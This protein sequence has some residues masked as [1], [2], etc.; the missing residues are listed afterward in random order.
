[1]SGPD[2][3][4]SPGPDSNS[5]GNFVIGVST[6]GDI[7]PFNYLRTIISQ[8]AN[9]EI[10]T[11]LIANMD[12]Y[13]DQTAN[14]QSLFDMIWNVDTAQGY[15]LDVWGRIVG[16]SRTLNVVSPGDYFGF[17]EALPGSQ[18]F[19]QSPFYI[20]TPLTTNYEL[21]DSAFRV[22][23]FAKALSN[24]CDGSIPAIN[25]I[26]MKLFPNRGNA[27]V[28]DGLDMTMIYKF[29]FV[30]TP[31]ELAIVL[32]SGVLPKPTGVSATVQQVG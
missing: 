9:S 1:M 17:Q 16:V 3:P 8:Y 10:L 22:L 12:A 5:I 6:I 13:I 29:E 23:I 7:P 14:F 11:R 26:L 2:Y 24:I 30:L 15:G 20:G 27:Y 19:N 28:V 32:Q 31:V 21:S 4:P 18:P 25:Q